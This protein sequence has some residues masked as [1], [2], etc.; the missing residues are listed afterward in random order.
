MFS[1]WHGKT[2]Q[3]L[4]YTASLVH[5]VA[6]LIHKGLEPAYVHIQFDAQNEPQLSEFH[7]SFLFH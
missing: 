6:V 3:S 1:L 2:F 4:L 7:V 5:H